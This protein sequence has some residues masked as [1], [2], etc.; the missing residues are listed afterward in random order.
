MKKKHLPKGGNTMGNEPNDICGIVI[1]G[2][3]EDAWVVDKLNGV[4]FKTGG[5]FDDEVEDKSGGCTLD[6][7]GCVLPAED[8]WT[9][10][11]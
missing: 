6:E 2:D 3:D 5:I 11:K 10:I 1:E 9:E 8:V 4:K 7:G